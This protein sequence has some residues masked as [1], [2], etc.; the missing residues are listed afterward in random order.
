MFLLSDLLDMLLPCVYALAG[1]PAEE[2]KAMEKSVKTEVEAA[3]AAAQ[4]A[5]IPPLPWLHRNV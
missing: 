5:P 3:V 4:A 2:L 1:Y